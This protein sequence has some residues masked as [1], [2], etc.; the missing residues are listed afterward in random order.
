M[1]RKIRKL[2]N[3]WTKHLIN[4]KEITVEEF[5]EFLL[6]NPKLMKVGL[7]DI[8]LNS[9]IHRG[10]LE[11]GNNS[12]VLLIGSF[13]ENKDL[14]LVCC[15]HPYSQVV[16]NIHPY[17]SSSEQ[18]RGNTDFYF[19]ELVK[20]FRENTKQLKFLFTVPSPCVHVIKTM[21]KIEASL[22]GFI[23][24]GGIWRNKLVDL[25]LFT[26]DLYGEKHYGK[27]S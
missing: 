4:T 23:P 17:L 11:S 15:C 26:F 1:E 7:P 6:N 8:D 14:K 25:L 21:T 20:W 16:V 18:C 27:R 19:T 5:E 9:M 13:D 24:N 12:N 10:K 3:L 22:S 2:N